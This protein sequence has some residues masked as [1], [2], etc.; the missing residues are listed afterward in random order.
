MCAVLY[1]SSG[2][3]PSLT[4]Q[5]SLVWVYI[6]LMGGPSLAD[7]TPFISRSYGRCDRLEVAP[8]A[9]LTFGLAYVLYIRTAVPTSDR[10]GA[11][12]FWERVVDV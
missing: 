2:F 12:S 10:R 6:A 1:V 11:I 7:V 8:P 4:I 3:A 9:V 5:T